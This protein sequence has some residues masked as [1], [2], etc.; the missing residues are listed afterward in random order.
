MTYQP[1][2]RVRVEKLVGPRFESDW[3]EKATI[4]KPRAENLPMPP[5]YFLVR[6]DDGVRVLIP[7]ER[8]MPDNEAA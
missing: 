3:T 8:L 5:G 6:F 1:K 4:M 7:K 2:Q